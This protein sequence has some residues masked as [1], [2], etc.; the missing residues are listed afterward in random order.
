VQAPGEE[1]VVG[2]GGQALNAMLHA[3]EAL[4][5]ERG[6]DLESAFATAS[7]V[8]LAVDSPGWE[9]GADDDDARG[10]FSSV[11]YAPAEPYLELG[12]GPLFHFEYVLAALSC[13]GA[14]AGVTVT[15]P[16]A[17]CIVRRNPPHFPG[18]LPAAATL[19]C[20]HCAPGDADALPM[21][22]PLDPI[23]PLSPS[24]APAALSSASSHTAAPG[25]RPAA[26][27]AAH[28]APSV[29][30][31][32]VLAA[33]APPLSACVYTGADA[34]AAPAA[35]DFWGPSGLLPL[36]SARLAAVEGPPE[37]CAA[38]ARA[39][40]GAA[41]AGDTHALLLGG[42]AV[43]RPPARRGAAARPPAPAA[44]L[45]AAVDRARGSA[46]A[47]CA[48]G[49]VERLLA[50]QGLCE[51]AALARCASRARGIPWAEAAEPLLAAAARAELDV[52][53]RA[54]ACLADLVAACAPLGACRTN[55]TRLVPPRTNWIRLVPP[56]V[57]HRRLCTPR[58]VPRATCRRRLPPRAAR[59]R[60]DGG[61]ARQGRASGGAA[62]RRAARSGRR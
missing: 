51:R 18:E 59:R 48:A 19:L 26:A 10:S 23:V 61:R 33:A 36:L 38:L 28:L 20:A 39:L 55:W 50:R 16:G 32:L 3:F 17:G 31:A 2:S 57:P 27:W 8:V 35:L 24:P 25:A 46:A 14:R 42:G 47:A 21:V 22:V 7:V 58:C 62:A 29:A 6:M 30:R 5:A 43:L 49:V 4:Q 56:P 54:L 41:P 44:A 45:R 34:G 1:S 9:E 53:A 37:P 52:A 40:D 13:I 15:L 60:G 12:P 11:P